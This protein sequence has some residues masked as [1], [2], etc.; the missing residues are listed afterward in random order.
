MIYENCWQASVDVE[1]RWAL[2]EHPNRLDARDLFLLAVSTRLA[3]PTKTHY[4]EKIRLVNRILA[5]N[6]DNLQ[7]LERKARLHAEYV[8]LGYSSDPAADLTLAQ[9][10]VNRMFVID[11][12]NLLA[13]RAKANVL[14]A[15]GDW[16]DAE[17]IVRRAIMLQ[18]TEALRHYELGLILMAEGRHREAL[19]SFQNS[20]RFA[21]GSDPVYAIDANIAMAD[22]ALG[23]SAEAIDAARLSISEFPPDTGRL[24]E[25]A[26]L[27]LIAADNNDG[28]ASA[29]R[30]NLQKFLST[31]RSWAS[32]AQVQTYLAFAANPNLLGGL[33][34]AG[35]PAR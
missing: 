23:L 34:Q 18:P 22:V 20:R 30:A 24:E 13:M 3:T 1:A 9:E 32:L 7:G 19:A 5:L 29:A 28:N 27:A 35:M 10:A 15:Q 2:R 16:T 6:P 21:G 17:P 11:P 8:L 31:T 33:R 25:L 12:N 26:W 4:E 14:R